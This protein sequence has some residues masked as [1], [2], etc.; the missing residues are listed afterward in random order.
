LEAYRKRQQAA[1]AA[2]AAA[3]AGGEAAEAAAAARVAFEGAISEAFEPALKHYVS[4]EQKEVSFEYA[5]S[6]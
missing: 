2:K 6:S 4:E 3:E 5:W 1:A